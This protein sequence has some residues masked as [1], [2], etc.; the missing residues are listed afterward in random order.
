[1]QSYI[2]KSI[3]VLSALCVSW[4]GVAFTWK[5]IKPIRWAFSAFLVIICCSVAL[6]IIGWGG[7]FALNNIKNNKIYKIYKSNQNNDYA[8]ELNEYTKTLS[9]NAQRLRTSME[10]IEE[11]EAILNKEKNALNEEKNAL[12][13]E[14]LKN[15]LIKVNLDE[16]KL[17]NE[18]D[19]E[20]I[21]S[22]IIYISPKF[23]KRLEEEDDIHNEEL[24]MLAIRF[25]KSYVGSD[26]HLRMVKKSINKFSPLYRPTVNEC[27]DLIRICSKTSYDN[28]KEIAKGL[29]ILLNEHK[30]VACSLAS[31]TSNTIPSLAPT[32]SYVSLN[33]CYKTPARKTCYPTKLSNKSQIM[34][35][36]NNSKSISS[37][38][39]GM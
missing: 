34:L 15:N 26:K 31:R 13:E 21:A 20:Q 7:S 2:K 5:I 6:N 18:K 19:K 39:R 12:N 4:F 10:L 8:L 1:M 33:D 35:A 25:L 29:I 38:R 24:K 11:K 16:E 17:K 32:R 27:D 3:I 37:F 22:M 30:D 28:E 36:K 14:K 9:K 23:E